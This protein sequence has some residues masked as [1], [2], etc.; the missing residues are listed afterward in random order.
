MGRAMLAIWVV[1]VAVAGPAFGQQAKPQRACEQR[2]VHAISISLK[3]GWRG[4]KEVNETYGPP[5][6][7]VIIEHRVDIKKKE[8][9]VNYSVSTLPDKFTGISAEEVKNAYSNL[10]ESAAKLHLVEYQAK[11]NLE[12]QDLLKRFEM[13]SVSS[14]VIEAKASIDGSGELELVVFAKIAKSAT[15]VSLSEIQRLHTENMRCLAADPKCNNVKDVLCSEKAWLCPEG[16]V[17][18]SATT[19]EGPTPPSTPGPK[20]VSKP[21]YDPVIR[22]QVP[23]TNEHA[24]ATAAKTPVDNGIIMPP[25]GTAACNTAADK[26]MNPTS[27]IPTHVKYGADS[28]PGMKTTYQKLDSNKRPD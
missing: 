27:V 28:I 23:A 8:G 3:T 7:W 10:A 19:D 15:N 25:K 20:L 22:T 6:G 4:K 2:E 12:K 5:P 16:A 9:N 11:L 24:P 1:C 18:E 14:G 17:C 21:P 26:G 13:K